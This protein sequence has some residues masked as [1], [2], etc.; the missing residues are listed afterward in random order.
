[1]I[2]Q[3]DGPRGFDDESWKDHVST[4]SGVYRLRAWAES[5]PR[6]LT[7]ASGAVDLD[8]ILDIGTTSGLYGRLLELLRACR[9]G[10]G[11]HSAGLRFNHYGY[12]TAFPLESL[13]IEVLPL[14]TAPLA[15]ALELALIEHYIWTFKDSTPLNSTQ[16]NWRSVDRWLR[17]QGREPRRNGCVDLRGLL[18]DQR[19]VDWGA[20]DQAE[21]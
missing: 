19:V 12:A 20:V 6:H 18:P 11:S 14:A 17:S 5:G 16:G 9:H 15:E 2:V 1:M 3:F 13:R 4:S 8:G 21:E 10:R 7:R